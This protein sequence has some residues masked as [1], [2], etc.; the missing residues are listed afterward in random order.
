[1]N[2][3]FFPV[4]TF[5]SLK[6]FAARNLKKNIYKNLQSIKI[7]F[8]KTSFKVLKNVNSPKLFIP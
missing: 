1:M 4:K 2:N 3:S 8:Q 7:F 5:F 6:L